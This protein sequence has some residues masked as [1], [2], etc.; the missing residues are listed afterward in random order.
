MY[1]LI[2]PILLIFPSLSFAQYPTINEKCGTNH[3]LNYRNQLNPSIESGI[4][5]AE[6]MANDW[7]QHHP[8]YFQN[9]NGVLRIPVVFHVVYNTNDSANQYIHDSL[10][11]SQLNVL[12]ED[13]RRMNVDAVN[14]RNIF[15]SVAVDMGI[16]FCL[17]SVDPTGNPTNG[18]TR[19]PTTTNHFAT[20]FT[21][22]VKSDAAGGKDPWPTDQYL[23]IWVCDMSFL[24]QPLVLGYAQFP[25]DDPTTDGVV[26]QYQYIGKTNYVSTSPSNLGRTTTHEVG[27]WCGLRHVWGDGPCNAD[28]FVWDTPNA[29][30][31]SNFDCD[32]TKNTCD[33]LGNLYWGNINPPNMIENFMDYSADDCMNMFSRGQRD[34][35]WSFL[36]TDRV[37]LFSSNGCG[38][39]GLFAQSEINDVS[40][41]GNCDGEITVHP[42]NGIAPFTFLWDDALAQT[43][44][45]ATNLCYGNY[46]CRIIDANSDTIYVDVDIANPLLMYNTFD[47]THASCNGCL[48]GIIEVNTWGGVPPYTFTIDNGTPQ[49]D[50]MFVYLDPGVYDITITD[51]CGTTYNEQIT[52]ISTLEIN[53]N[54]INIAQIYP[55][56]T[57][58]NLNFTFI[59]NHEKCIQIYNATGE[60]VIDKKSQQMNEVIDLQPL[61][62]GVYFIEVKTDGITN[63]FKILKN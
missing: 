24:G 52:V 16:E 21:Q 14:T 13:F 10:I 35:V 57:S 22:S 26:I 44:S 34:R 41:L 42:I 51:S 43:D 32:T 23:N 50:S 54:N 49:S 45:I 29:D 15:D 28:D 12:N 56:P 38:L 59:N 18:I 1:K 17:A 39:P 3:S 9:R 48:D 55:N 36:M 30:A 33:D 37:S 5:Q 20:P 8:S 4:Q 27:H 46:T 53:E 58:G 2:L 63:H 6:N 60:L 40:C 61:R 11:Y 62:K 31:Q 19:T 7:L 25:G 47:V